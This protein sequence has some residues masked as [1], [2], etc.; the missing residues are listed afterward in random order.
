MA[1]DGTL[2]ERIGGQSALDAAVELF[3]ERLL[4]EPSLSIFFEGVDIRKLKAHQ[5]IFMEMAFNDRIPAGTDVAQLMARAH[6]RLFSMGLNET[7]FDT[8][9]TVL[10]GTLKT[11]GVQEQLIK[12][13]VSVVAPLR[14]TFEDN[15]LRPT[16]AGLSV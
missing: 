4:Q 14:V 12:E 5:Y 16:A 15:A 6:R 7:H 10:V 11:L 13:V 3:Y 9:A 8:V 1:A 2:F